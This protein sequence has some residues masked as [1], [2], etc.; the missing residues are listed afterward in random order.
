MIKPS[1]ITVVVCAI[2]PRAHLL[3]RAITSILNQ[4]VVPGAINVRYDH[5]HIGHAAN[6]NRALEDVRTD[7]VAFLDDDDE[8]DP[9]H[10]ESLI[11]AQHGSGADLVYPWHRIKNRNGEEIRDLLIHP[12]GGFNEAALRQHN[13]IPVTVLARTFDLYR[14][15]FPE[16][17]PGGPFWK[18]EDWGC[19]L[20]MLDN[21]A[22]F[23]HHPEVT[24]TWWHHGENTS[25]QG[26]K[27]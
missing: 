9:N 12:E 21:G 26:D 18:C 22:K 8:W 4:T 1:D 16:S 20:R 27:W 23:Y 14:A 6:R 3:A 15:R 13:Y 25:G 24:W 10:L 2:P 5:D 11:G 19:W 17:V 7:W